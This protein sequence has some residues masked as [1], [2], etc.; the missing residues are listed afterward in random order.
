LGKIGSPAVE[1]LSEALKDQTWTDRAVAAQ[2]LGESKDPRALEPL[3]AAL[4][5]PDVE[6]R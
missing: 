2:A 3:I 1:T 6:V 5:D 4:R